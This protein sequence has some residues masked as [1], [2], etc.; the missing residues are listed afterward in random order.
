MDPC[1]CNA[2]TQYWNGHP[3]WIGGCLGCPFSRHAAIFGV[4]YW[5]VESRCAF[6]WLPQ[7]RSFMDRVAEEDAVTRAAL[8]G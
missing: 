6:D 1:H 7:V 3:C 4:I 2:G 8:H 5:G